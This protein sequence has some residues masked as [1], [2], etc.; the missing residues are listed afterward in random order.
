MTTHNDADQ[1]AVQLLPEALF[2][3]TVAPLPGI[4]AATAST[5]ARPR[6]SS[7]SRSPLQPLLTARLP[8]TPTWPPSSPSSS[9]GMAPFHRRTSPPHQS[10]PR[11]H[12]HPRQ[13]RP[14]CCAGSPI[15]PW[16]PRSPSSLV[17][18]SPA[19]PTVSLP[20]LTSSGFSS[21][22][23]LR[24]ATSLPAGD[25]PHPGE[26]LRLLC[27]LVRLK[28]WRPQ[29]CSHARSPAYHATSLPL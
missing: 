27:I 9:S 3:A 5:H 12:R 26:P 10:F 2:S 1:D 28:H 24:H 29:P 14:R 22:P 13:Q 16:L 21:V 7:S 19:L 18:P 6:A 8:S 11:R 23:L 15:S 25:L 17:E 20:P 4:T